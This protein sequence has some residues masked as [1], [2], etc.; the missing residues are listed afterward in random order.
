MAGFDFNK[1]LANNLLFLRNATL[2][3]DFD[4][5]VI[6]DGK[7]GAGKSVLGQQVAAFLDVDHKI[8]LATQ[9]CF[10]PEQF[11]KAVLTLKKGKA[12]IWDEARSGL[13]R[14]RAMNDTNIEIVDMLAECRQNNLFLVIIMPTFY[15]MDLNVAVHRTRAL[16]HVWY[17]WNEK[18]P[19][20]PLVRGFFRFYN[21]DG[22]Q[23]L[24]TNKYYRAAYKYPRISG[25]YFDGTFKKHYVVDEE[26]YKEAKKQAIRAYKQDDDVTKCPECGRK[27]GRFNRKDKLM[28]CGVC[29][30]EYDK[31]K[32]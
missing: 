3:Q 16:I 14:R 4:A 27:A 1:T 17:L 8:D 11:N 22:K 18:K 21:E 31:P 26:A 28:V 6:I 19:E 29:G 10:S 20:K 24:Y 13:N 25:C 5:A 2:K 15:D 23:A 12:V 9:M 30:C 32:I 7:E